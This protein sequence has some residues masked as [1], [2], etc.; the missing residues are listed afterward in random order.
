MELIG[1]YGRIYTSKKAFLSDFDAGKDFLVVD[2][3]R[4]TYGSKNDLPEGNYQ[5]R[6]GKRLEKVFMLNHKN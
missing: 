3:L 2:F 5:C 1:A 6:Y 4:R